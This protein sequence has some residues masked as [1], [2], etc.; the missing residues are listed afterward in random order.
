MTVKEAI[1]R[2]DAARANTVSPDKKIEW[3]NQIDRQIFDDV[4]KTHE[5]P[6]E[7]P[8]TPYTKSNMSAVLLVPDLYAELYEYYIC[9]QI[10]LMNAEMLKYQNSAALYNNTVQAFYNW[11][12]RTHMPIQG[13]VLNL[14]LR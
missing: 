1:D 5:S 8:F 7:E 6:P 11:Y 13:T 9:M 12:N 10:D 3:L 4:F 2:A 14:H